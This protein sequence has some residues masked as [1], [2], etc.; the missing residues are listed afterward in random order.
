MSREPLQ[1]RLPAHNSFKN[2]DQRVS[3]QQISE[4]ITCVTKVAPLTEKRKISWRPLKIEHQ[5]L[6]PI[7]WPLPPARRGGKGNFFC[8]FLQAGYARLQKP[9]I[10][11]PPPQRR[12]R[13]WGGGRGW[14]KSYSSQRFIHRRLATWRQAE[15]PPHIFIF[16]W[17]APAHGVSLENRIR[18]QVPTWT[19][20]HLRTF[21][22]SRCYRLRDPCR[23]AFNSPSRL[24]D[25]RTIP[26]QDG[27]RM[28]H[29]SRLRSYWS[30]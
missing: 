15:Q 14:G 21:A 2:R 3:N 10:F 20:Y 27:K 1:S 17:C 28:A 13:R 25:E 26:W 16:G 7:P 18:A 22:R 30:V 11:S 12:L 19:R 29:R 23:A 6:P 5:L 9:F 8:G 4:K 24:D